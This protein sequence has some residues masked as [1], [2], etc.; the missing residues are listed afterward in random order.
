[1]SRTRLHTAE[2]HT[3]FGAADDF[4]FEERGQDQHWSIPLAGILI[5]GPLLSGL[6]WLLIGFIGWSIFA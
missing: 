5:Y 1:M 3:E 6:L 4:I 2:Q